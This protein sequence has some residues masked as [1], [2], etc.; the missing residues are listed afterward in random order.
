MGVIGIPEKADP[1]PSIFASLRRCV[2]LL[3]IR[4]SDRKAM[5]S[6]I[7]AFAVP[8]LD[9]LDQRDMIGAEIGEDVINTR[10][11]ETLEE[12]NVRRSDGSSPFPCVSSRPLAGSFD[13]GASV[14]CQG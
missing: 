14:I 4:S 9:L 12:N 13:D 6:A 10:I 8:A 3:C 1:W 5:I 7:K 11:G 2:I